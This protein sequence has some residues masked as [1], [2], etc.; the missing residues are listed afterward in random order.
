MQADRELR[1]ALRRDCAP[2]GDIDIRSFEDTQSTFVQLVN[3]VPF[4][5][6]RKDLTKLSIALTPAEHQRFTNAWRKAI[7]YGEKGT[8]TADKDLVI[9]KAREIYE[10]YPDILSRLGF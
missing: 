3:N 6:S 10:N 1:R 2:S 5:P 4:F 9:Q 8:G 7:E